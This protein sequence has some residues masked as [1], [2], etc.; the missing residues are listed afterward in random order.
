MRYTEKLQSWVVYR[1]TVHKKP[2]GT[3]VCEQQEWD[4]MERVHHGRHTL[5]HS[6][7]ANEGEAERL[8]RSNAV[9]ENTKN[10]G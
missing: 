7:V 3:A 8:A 4:A 2:T 9:D 6:G 10:S 5:I 1:I